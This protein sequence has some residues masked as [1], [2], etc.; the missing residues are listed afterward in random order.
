MLDQV[1]FTTLWALGGRT[2]AANF[3]INFHSQEREISG[4]QVSFILGNS[5]EINF[6][7][8]IC[9]KKQNLELSNAIT[10]L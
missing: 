1:S 6:T 4:I 7:E 2:R 3:L 8:A 9:E 5:R 10:H